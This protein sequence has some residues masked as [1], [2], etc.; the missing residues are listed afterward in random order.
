M[1][2]PII[3]EQAGFGSDLARA[4]GGGASRGLTEAIE[5]YQQRKSS[6]RQ[7]SGLMPLLKEAGIELGEE[8]QRAFLQSGMTPEKILPFAAS[9][10]KQ[11]QERMAEES[12]MQQVEKS[13]AQGQH[14]FDV[15]T[16]MLKKNLPGIGISP[17]TKVGL[18][19]AGV[20]NRALFNTLRSKFEATLLP[21]VNKG[22][23]AKERFNYIMSLIPK[24]EESQRSIAGKLF[25]LG[26]E[27]G[28]DTSELS[29]IPWAKEA[30]EKIGIDEDTATGQTEKRVSLK[31]IFG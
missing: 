18:N 31:E 17:T 10:A 11:K 22:T 12:Q 14:V 30:I 20:Q 19:R 2:I 25:A 9:L 28:Y 5:N 23:L 4:L 27:L 16:K 6:E 13:K 8:D 1:S 29:Q 7:L 3:E 21:M 15:A 24:A 26:E